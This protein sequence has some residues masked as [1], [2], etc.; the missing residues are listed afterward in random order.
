MHRTLPKLATFIAVLAAAPTA[1]AATDGA[2][3]APTYGGAGYGE[4]QQPQQQVDREPALSVEDPKPEPKKK[5]GKKRSPKATRSGR[6]R[7]ASFGVRGSRLYLYGRAAKVKFQIDGRTPTVSVRLVVSSAKT[8][9][10]VRRIELGE[11]ATGVPHAYRLTGREGGA[12]KA[13]SYRVRVKARDARG[14]RLVRSAQTSAVDE[15][16]VYPYRFPLKGNFPFGDSGSRFGDPRGGREHQGQ[17]IAAPEGTPLRAV[18][19]GVVKTVAYQASGAGHYIVISGA[20][21]KRDYVY[22]HLQAGSIRIKQG[23]RVKTGKWI[24]NVGNTGAS[25]GAH[26]HFEIWRGPWW[27]GGEPIDPYPALRRWDRWS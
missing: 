8:G 4:P 7:L 11:Q 18:R 22:M 14:R 13:G 27:G 12:L 2:A 21:Q 16:G 5:R 17:D 25:F 9:K 15:I 20:G 1:A 26:L 3:Q 23:Q 24:G 19:G 10:A 6:P